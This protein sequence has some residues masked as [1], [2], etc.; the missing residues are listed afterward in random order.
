MATRKTVSSRQGMSG[1]L[2]V[3]ESAG[4]YSKGMAYNFID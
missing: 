1:M 3:Q 4:L 2:P